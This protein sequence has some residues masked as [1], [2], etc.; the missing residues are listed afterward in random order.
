MTKSKDLSNLGG[1]FLQSGTGTVQRA[2]ENKLKDIVSIK[3]FGAVG[4]GTTND[5]LSL[6]AAAQSVFFNSYV[7]PGNY[8]ASSFPNKAA[9]NNV[10]FGPGQI[11]TADGNKTGRFFSAIKSPP[12][13]SGN[14]NSAETAFNGD[15]SKCQFPVEHR[16]TGALTLGQPSSGY[17]Y[18]AEAYPH[19]TYIFN[20]SGW[21][22]ATD[23]N[24]GRTGATA[25]R[26]KSFQAGQGDLVCFNGS[27]FVTGTRAGSTTWLANPAAV[28]FNGD[29]TAGADGVY[30]NP[31]E[32][33]C[34]DLGYDVA[35]VGIVN[36]FQRTN[37][38][39]AKGTVW[40][41]YRAQNQGTATCDAMVSGTGQWVTGLDLTM[42][43]FGAN[44]AAISLK[45][46]DRIYLNNNANASGSLPSGF[47]TTGFNGD[48]INFSADIQGLNFVR[49]GSSKLQIT[50]S[51][52]TV[53]NSILVV[54]PS[55]GVTTSAR[56]RE[57][58]PGFGV[59]TG[60]VDT[61]SFDPASVTLEQLAKYVAGMVK[62]LHT[63]TA[64]GHH[65]FT[66]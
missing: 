61:S 58:Q 22:Q 42:A 66:S 12:S 14:Q 35:C 8:L 36:N 11:I 56:I 48:Y 59:P 65:L 2:V 64:D 26:V 41:G 43:N 21:N 30:L 29:L 51:Q 17:L 19:Y 60:L 20:S 54:S 55:P 45:S 25:Y 27:A 62:R 33:I 46:G 9:L 1:G 49:G 23:G 44:L 52:V 4:N 15:L 7:P 18:T 13:S 38:T 47:R 37:A 16:I 31:Y 10:L 3:D 53:A 39:G 32:T 63:S 5:S 40:L 24:N 57:S 50:S 6:T 28:L 34:T